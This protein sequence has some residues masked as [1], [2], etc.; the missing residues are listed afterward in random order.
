MHHVAHV[1]QSFIIDKSEIINYHIFKW[2]VFIPL[3]I[4]Y[5]VIPVCN[6]NSFINKP[7][8]SIEILYT[9]Q[10]GAFGVI[11]DCG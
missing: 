11:W 4:V 9:R 2:V 6:E 5:F 10:E 1:A 8:I 3:S 7:N